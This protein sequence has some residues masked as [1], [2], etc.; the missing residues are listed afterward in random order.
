VAGKSAA[1]AAAA[2]PKS[3]AANVSEESAILVLVFMEVPSHCRERRIR[4]RLTSKNAGW[5]SKK[6]CWINSSEFLQK[7]LRLLQR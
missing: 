7:M 1:E 3:P 4:T 5:L 2:N 6:L